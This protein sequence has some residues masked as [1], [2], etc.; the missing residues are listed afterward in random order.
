MH[1]VHVSAFALD[2]TERT[3]ADIVAWLATTKV[4]TIQNGSV[5]LDGVEVVQVDNAGVVSRSKR[6]L[7][8]RA[9]T[10]QLADPAY[11]DLPVTSISQAGARMYCRSLGFD[12][13][14]E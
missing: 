3:N 6:A 10:V 9:S 4:V 2:R 7:T 14:T 1:T 11:A 12:L 13:P 8:I 5:W